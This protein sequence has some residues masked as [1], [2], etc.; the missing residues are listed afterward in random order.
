MPAGRG[1]GGGGPSSLPLVKRLRVAASLFAF[2]AVLQPVQASISPAF[3]WAQSPED[4]HI[5][6][7]FAHK[8]DAPAYNKYS[9]DDIAVQITPTGVTM[10]ASNSEKTFSLSLEL[11]KKIDPEKSSYSIH[12]F[13]VSMVLRKEKKVWK[14]LLRDK[15]LKPRNMHMWWELYEKY[16]DDMEKLEEEME[17]STN[18]KS[19]KK[20]WKSFDHKCDSCRFMMQQAVFSDDAIRTLKKAL[21]QDQ[22]K[23]MKKEAEEAEQADDDDHSAAKEEDHDTSSSGSSNET[24]TETDDDSKHSNDSN[25]DSNKDTEARAKANVRVALGAF[26]RVCEEYDTEVVSDSFKR[27]CKKLRRRRDVKYAAMMAMGV[28]LE[29]IRAGDEDLELSMLTPEFVHNHTQAACSALGGTCQGLPKSLTE[30][31]A[32]HVVA[33]SLRATVESYKAFPA[34]DTLLSP[35]CDRAAAPHALNE[36]H[37]AV[38]G[39]V[40]AKLETDGFGSK[41]VKALENG[42]SERRNKKRMADVCRKAGFCKKKK[43]PSNHKS[44]KAEEDSS[45]GSGGDEKTTETSSEK[46]EASDEGPVLQ[47]ETVSD[48]L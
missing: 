44:E 32:C 4:I 15:N 19:D 11:F 29:K 46:T 26:R 8:I 48:E 22:A 6:V 18:K 25:D 17:L 36:N 1:G 30:C 5:Y 10:D 12:T 34:R 38:I 24:E 27:A 43:K 37:A 31:K 47:T 20:W 7:K 13:G 28:V 35:M 42:D 33:G 16:N 23:Q 3:K 21:K 40:C 2:F 9:K 41:M 14:R 39:R 45:S